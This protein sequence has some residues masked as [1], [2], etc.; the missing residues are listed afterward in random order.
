MVIFWTLGSL[1]LLTLDVY[2]F[3]ERNMRSSS[4]S[5]KTEK[6]RGP[7]GGQPCEQ[8]YVIVKIVD[9]KVVVPGD[10]KNGIIYYCSGF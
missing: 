4:R 3:V 6:W 10:R 8:T 5:W 2:F 9:K 7:S 1:F